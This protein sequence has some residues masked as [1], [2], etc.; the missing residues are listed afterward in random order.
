MPVQLVPLPDHRDRLIVVGTSV[1]KPLDILSP[2]LQSLAWQELPPRTRLHF[3]FVDDFLPS[4]GDAKAYLQDFLSTRGGELLRGLP[5]AAGDF[6]DSAHL[7]S[8][9]WSLPSMQRVGLHKNKILKRALE[10]KADACFL[11]DSDL[12]LDR[13][14]LTSLIALDRPIA[15]AV[16]WTK[17][18]RQVT[19]TGRIWASPQVWLRH[20]YFLDGRGMDEATFRAKLISRQVTRVW[21]QGACSLI[22]RRVL[23][24]GIDFSPASEIPQVGLMGGED[25]QFCVK[26][27]RGHLDMW[28]DPWPDIFHVYHRAEHVTQIPAMLER[29]G[30]EHPQSPHVG[31]LVNLTL[32]ALEPIPTPQGWS[33]I[34]P[35]P[36]RGRLGQLPLLPELEEAILGLTRGQETIVPIHFPIHYPMPYLRGRRRLIRVQLV[37]CKPNSAPPVLEDDLHQTRSGSVIDLPTLTDQ[38]AA[39]LE[40]APLELVHG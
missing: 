15:C 27:E 28:A 29:L 9:T 33:Q 34:A 22:A 21:G 36:I 40:R 31:D 13:T 8:H 1:R 4:H 18:A 12:I 23:E 6:D 16:Y 37:D 30:A 17:W 35:Q 11:V 3:V 10:L 14:V 20:P 7:P 32:T 38:Q 19:E 25:R 5:S 39:A 2:F 24:A 26:A